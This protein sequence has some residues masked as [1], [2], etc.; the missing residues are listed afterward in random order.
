MNDNTEQQ[1][2]A[3]LDGSDDDI[4]ARIVQLRAERDAYHALHDGLSDMIESGRLTQQD[5]PDDYEWL[6]E[7]LANMPA[8]PRDQKEDA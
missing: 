1:K 8:R 6:V 5:I 7:S 3:A 4:E 2:S